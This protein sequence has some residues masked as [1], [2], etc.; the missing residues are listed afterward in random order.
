MCVIVCIAF[1]VLYKVFKRQPIAIPANGN[2]RG[3]AGSGTHSN[4]QEQYRDADRGNVY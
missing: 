2:N 4:Y 3:L 1:I